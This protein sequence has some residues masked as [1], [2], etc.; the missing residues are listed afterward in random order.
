MKRT[1]RILNKKFSHYLIPAMLTTAALSLSEFVDSMIVANLLGSEAMSIIQLGMP[2]M[3]IAATAYILIG[4]GGSTLYA[5]YLGKHENEKAGKIFGLSAISSIIIGF[6]LLLLGLLLFK[7][8]ASVLCR[9]SELAEDFGKYLMTLLFS[10]P[11]LVIT[12]SLVSFLA[13]AGAPQISTV[14]NI[15][16]NVVNVGMDYV[17]IHFFDM[18]VSGAALATLTGYVVGAIP[19]F[20]A[21][22]SKKIGL[23]KQMPKK[24]DIKILKEI[25]GTGRSGSASQLGFAIRTAFCNWLAIHFGG[26]AGVVSISIC[27]QAWSIVS[28]FMSAV[29]E[30]ASPIIGMLHGQQDY[31]GESNVL[32]IGLLYQF[33]M[34]GL[35]TVFFEFFPQ[36]FAH[37][38]SVNDEEILLMSNFA[39]R[40]FAISL[41]IR[42]F[43]IVFMKYIQILGFKKYALFISL[44]DGFAGIIPI[45]YIFSFTL[46]IEGFWISFPATSAILLIICI[47]S[48]FVFAKKSNGRLKGLLLEEQNTEEPTIVDITIFES[49]KNIVDASEN[50]MKICSDYGIDKKTSTTLALIVEESVLYTKNRS[51]TQKKHDYIDI[52]LRIYENKIKI[53]FRSLHSGANPEYKDGRDIEE[54][55]KVL[56]SISDK[57]EYDYIMGMH[58][59]YI[60]LNKNK[61]C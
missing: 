38:Y 2:I 41:L 54:N 18:G 50:V 61:S 58:C 10:V 46:G 29:V 23:K 4:N 20:I 11:F 48:N 21:I 39:L 28:I 45:S 12:L 9:T 24:Q 57:I 25:I 49:D 13:P 51:K 5:I 30:A 6:A 27:I 17:Y 33:I 15:I 34:L 22:F 56:E 16:A 1:N 3:L 8:L 43:Y 40:L 35:C 53:S 47:V 32:K 37:I 7:P 60:T 26:I 36:I 59:M 55:I 31:K 52:L 19:L 14:V 42:G 44:F